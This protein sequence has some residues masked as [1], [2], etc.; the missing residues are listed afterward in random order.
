MRT[1]E[2]RIPDTVGDGACLSRRRRRSPGRRT[3]AEVAEQGAEEAPVLG[4]VDRGQR[5]AEQL[6]P[7]AGD[8]GRE[9]ERRLTAELDDHAF[10][11]LELTDVECALERERFE[12][13]P[14]ARVVVGRHRFRVGVQQ[15][16]LV[17]EPSESQ[18][19]ARAAIVELDSLT[20][21]VGT[22]AEDDDRRVRPRGR[23]IRGFVGEV[24]V[25]R[26]GLELRGARIHGETA[27]SRAAAAHFVL[28]DREHEGHRCIWQ[29]EPLRVGDVS[30]RGELALGACDCPQLVREI[31][32]DSGQVEAA[33]CRLEQQVPAF[34]DRVAAT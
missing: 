3:H 31:R 19:R 22:R 26:S 25:R 24:E 10:R 34:R 15:D 4:A 17:A 11:L 23:G 33:T 16:R 1:E 21:S 29:S 12:I 18:R 20:D 28:A 5:V 30:G 7:R 9:R 14:V 2:D 6:E 27:R 8:A 32:V 13:E